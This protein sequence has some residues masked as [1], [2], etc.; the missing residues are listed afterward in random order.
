MNAKI[1]E[2]YIRQV[3]T[4]CKN[5]YEKK[6]VGPI[7]EEDL[8]SFPHL[9]VFAC[10][11]D[12]QINADKAWAILFEIAQVLGDEQFSSFLAKDEKWYIDLFNNRKYHRFNEQQAKA[13]Y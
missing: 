12:S 7:S 8:K 9:F 10:I 4:I 5:D 3:L 1:T 6:L 13:L 2:E 11:M